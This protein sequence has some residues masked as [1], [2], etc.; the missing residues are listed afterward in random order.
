MQ[1]RLLLLTS[2]L[3]L[4]VVISGCDGFLGNDAYDGQGELILNIADRPVNDVAEILVTIDEVQVNREGESWQ[5][6]NDFEDDGG[7]AEFD[8]L[9]LRFD[10][11]LLGQ[12]T[13]PAG[14]YNQ[15]RLIVAAEEEG[16]DPTTAGKSKVVYED[17][18][19][20]DE[21]IFIPSGMQTGLKIHYDFT[22]EDNSFTEL[23]L[24]FNVDEVMH[25]AGE[26]DKIILRPTA[27]DVIDESVAWNLTGRVL[28]E[29]DEDPEPIT[30]QD[31]IIE[32][33]DGEGDLEAS[34]LA[35]DEAK[36]D[37]DAGE[38]MLRGLE[39][40]T[41]DLEVFVVDADGEKDT[42]EYQDATVKN[43]EVG[44]DQENELDEDIILNKNNE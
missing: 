26:S 14:E 9:K 43:V 35:L 31:V 16:N 7:E 41:Y 39:E 17:E 34:T 6:I 4:A 23:T 42:S 27:I 3:I 40:G 21:N 24:D 12:E 25:E 15:I 44:P 8:L 11:E 18:D 2:F 32:A 5:V 30:D 1:K 33:Y 20:D 36:N 22:V 19:K 37:R 28:G 29:A 10:E 38:F 13:I